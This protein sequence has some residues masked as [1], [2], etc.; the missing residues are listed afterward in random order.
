MS[1]LEQKFSAA[2]ENYND[3]PYLV[4]AAIAVSILATVVAGIR[5]WTKMV[6][7]LRL[8]MDDWLILVALVRPHQLF[9]RFFLS[10]TGP[11]RPSNASKLHISPS[12]SPL[13]SWVFSVGYLLALS[14][15]ELPSCMKGLR[16]WNGKGD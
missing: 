8:D 10:S 11:N 4:G 7:G 2:Y 12:Y 16:V 3:G 9:R 1:L 6:K 15:I 13:L 5:I 14:L